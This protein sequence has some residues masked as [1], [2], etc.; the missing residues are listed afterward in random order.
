MTLPT[1]A[2]DW[3]F[4]PNYA[5]AATGTAL[6]TN[7]TILKAF[8]DFITTDAAEWVDETNVATTAMNLWTVRYSCDSVTAGA[9]GDGVDRWDA[10][11]DLVWANA[12]SAHSW[13]VLRQT[14]I[15]ASAELLISCENAQVNGATLTVA[16]SPSAGFTGGTTTA[17][18][19]ATDE[20]VT[21]NNATWGGVG[22]SDASVKLHAMKSTDGECWRV[23]VC[24]GG[25]ANTAWIIE[26]AMPFSA[27]SWTNRMVMYAQGTSAATSALTNAFLNTN[28]NFGGRGTSTMS[29]YLAA[30]YYAAGL[31]NANITTANDLSSAWPFMPQQLVS[32]TASNRGFHG[33]LSD[34]W[35][36]SATVAAGSTY[37]STGT[38]H[39]FVQFGVGIFPWCQVAA[40]V[41]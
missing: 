38:Q 25:Q 14:A 35:Y 41:S 21:I 8:K 7:R 30:M 16:I 22:A 18:P 31:A 20:I 37:P 23:F 3:H 19:T 5:V 36:G 40:Q 17:R 34:L 39:Q 12:G 2:K 15:G 1:L 6:G 9:A 29:M 33:Y 4:V 24:N 28:A 10:I 27:A 26:K 13:I 11:T 32:A